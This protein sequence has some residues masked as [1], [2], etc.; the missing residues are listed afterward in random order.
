MWLG[1]VLEELPGEARGRRWMRGER[2]GKLMRK[3]MVME[4]STCVSPALLTTAC[5][6]V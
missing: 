6:T 1:V 5:L 4:K 3:S 2:E